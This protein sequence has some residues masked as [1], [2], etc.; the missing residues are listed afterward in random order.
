M[1]L[2]TTLKPLSYIH[3]DPLDEFHLFSPPVT[4]TEHLRP[5]SSLNKNTIKAHSAKRSD[6]K[7]TSGTTFCGIGR[8]IKTLVGL[9]PVISHLCSPCAASCNREEGSELSGGLS[10]ILQP[11]KIDN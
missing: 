7:Q 11:C 8:G 9:Q 4:T 3:K 10:E 6:I 1:C 5:P 2:H